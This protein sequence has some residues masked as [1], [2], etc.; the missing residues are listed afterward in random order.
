MKELYERYVKIY[1]NSEDIKSDLK[2][3]FTR[4][5]MQEI[6]V[7]LDF[8]FKGLQNKD[9]ISKRMADE[10]FYEAVKEKSG[11]R[12]ITIKV[13]KGEEDT[14]EKLISTLNILQDLLQDESVTIKKFWKN[15]KKE[16]DKGLED[17]KSTSRKHWDKIDEK[18]DLKSDRFQKHLDEL[19]K[20]DIP[21]EELEKL[22][23]RWG[24]L[25]TQLDKRIKDIR[26]EMKGKKEDVKEIIYEYIGESQAIIEDDEKDM[27]DLYPLWFDMVKDIRN[28]LEVS[29]DALEKKEIELI[30]TWDGLSTD[31]RKELKNLAK[32]HEEEMEELFKIWI[33]ISE[34]V[35]K[36]LEQLPDKYYDIYGELWKGFRK[37]RPEI[38][39]KLKELSEEY[40]ELIK[41]PMKSIKTT[42]KKFTKTSKDEEIQELKKRIAKLEKKLDEE[43]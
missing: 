10:K 41:D 35:D 2:E 30:K 1:E 12:E 38:K 37:K 25:T 7:D 5:E 42:Y 15:L 28:E 3:E 11:E 27:G 19:E 20:S 33:S 6:F 8:E 23:E 18:W 29:R 26:E 21:D 40:S 14:K 16:A 22:E 13:K 34:D 39:L 4:D 9:Q 31:L 43:D 24:K 32:E 17:V 36:L